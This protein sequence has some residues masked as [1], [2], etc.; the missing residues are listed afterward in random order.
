M[1]NMWPWPSRKIDAARRLGN[2]KHPALL[3]QKYHG[4]RFKAASHRARA[5]VASLHLQREKQGA[6]RVRK[7]VREESLFPRAEGHRPQGSGR[8]LD[9]PGSG[10]VA[11]GHR[12][13]RYIAIPRFPRVSAGL[14]KC[15][16]RLKSDPF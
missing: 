4:M 12:A 16:R 1:I 10:L 6:L 8:S 3:I 13:G 9:K 14:G 15:Q 11:H 2:N 7:Q 5:F